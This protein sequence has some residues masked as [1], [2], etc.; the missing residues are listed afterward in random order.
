MVAQLQIPLPFPLANREV[1]LYGYGDVQSNGSVAI[2][3]RSTNEHDSFVAASDPLPALS[4]SSSSTANTLDGPATAMSSSS[5][6][7][8]SSALSGNGIGGIPMKLPIAPSGYVRAQLYFGGFIITPKSP[9]KCEVT[10]RYPSHLLHSIPKP[11][12]IVH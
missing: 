4:S 12:S 11:L 3:F 9:H 8:S 5:S 1:L 6:S 2:F 7:S 10:T